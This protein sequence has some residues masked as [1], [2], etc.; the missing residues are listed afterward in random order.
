MSKVIYMVGEALFSFES[1]L[2]YV[3]GG[4]FQLE[5]KLLME[6]KEHKHYLTEQLQK[7]YIH[8]VVF[9]DEHGYKGKVNSF[10]ELGNM[11]IEKSIC[12]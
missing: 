4:E 8:D 1:N 11:K 5:E 6:I 9:E 7:G 12:S 3:S 10:E 2:Q